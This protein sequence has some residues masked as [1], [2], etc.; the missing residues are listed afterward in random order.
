MSNAGILGDHVY[1][2][3]NN[4]FAYLNFYHCASGYKMRTATGPAD[5]STPDLG[6]MDKTVFYRNQFVECGTAVDVVGRRQ[7]N[8]NVWFE[9]SFR[10]NTTTA[11]HSEP[12]A[13]TILASCEFINNHGNP[14]IETG[15]EIVNSY[16][17]AD[18]NGT[19]CSA[20]TP[21]VEGSTF[22]QGKSTTA[23]LLN[24]TLTGD[25][26]NAP[27]F[28]MMN[29]RSDLPLGPVDTSEVIALLVNNSLVAAD[30]RFGAPLVLNAYD[31]KG[32]PSVADMTPAKCTAYAARSSR[33]PRIAA[34]VRRRALT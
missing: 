2:I 26:R 25:A 3:D 1:G 34:L 4:M 32:T 22:E 24:L 16:F 14:V 27:I 19:R 21:T 8:L 18:E 31:T 29:S 11:F 30:A 10:D 23:Q 17:R 28:Y 20:E 15:V 9:S 33:N 12:D 6:Y 5:D 7:N 13:G